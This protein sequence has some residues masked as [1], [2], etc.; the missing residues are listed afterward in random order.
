M[1]ILYLSMNQKEILSDL[2]LKDFKSYSKENEN[3]GRQKASAAVAQIANDGD[4][5]GN[6]RAGGNRV[7]QVAVSRSKDDMD[8]AEV[9]TGLATNKKVEF[10][11]QKGSFIDFIR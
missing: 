3:K 10:T 9:G 8:K 2:G 11:L 1:D 6:L 7:A 4:T 5:V